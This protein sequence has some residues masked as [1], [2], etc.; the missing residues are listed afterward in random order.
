MDYNGL[1]IV[2]PQYYPDD[3][4]WNDF[5]NLWFQGYDLNTDI[6]EHFHYL[7]SHSDYLVMVQRPLNND[8]S[9]YEIISVSNEQQS[10][11]PA[12]TNIKEITDYIDLP[13]PQEG[14]QVEIMVASYKRLLED[15]YMRTEGL[16]GL[17]INPFSQKL[18]ADEKLLNSIGHNTTI[19]INHQEDLPSLVPAN[20]KFRK[21]MKI[22]HSNGKDPHVKEL[23]KESVEDLMEDGVFACPVLV[24]KK[25]LFEYPQTTG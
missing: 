23:L 9:D 5:F 16:S 21:N 14:Y 13:E 24:N 7:I 6:T 25:D 17:V 19:G 8:N 2:S 11:L 3:E 18:I 15:I 20:L 4:E 12:F 10:Y 22:Y 1:S